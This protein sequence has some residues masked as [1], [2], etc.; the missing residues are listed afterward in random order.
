MRNIYETFMGGDQ[1]LTHSSSRKFKLSNDPN[2][3]KWSKNTTSFGH[4]IM[5]EQGWTPGQFL[6]A[7]DAPHAEFHT[8]AN[9]SHIR[10]VLKDDNLGI[11][12][13]KGS[14]VNQ[15]ECVGLDV[16]QTLL[17]RLNSTDEEEYV[18]EQNRREDLK[19]AIYTEQKWGTIRFVHGGFLIG[20]KIQD[21][22]DGEKERLK[23]LKEAESDSESTSSD[24]DSDSDSDEDKLKKSKKTIEVE[25]AKLTLDIKSK[26]RKSEDD[27]EDK[28]AKK[29]RKAAEKEER[30]AQKAAE[31][32]DDSKLSKK[33]R[34]QKRKERKAGKE[35]KRT[36]KAA[37]KEAKA[38]AKKDGKK[39]KK[40][41][42]A[43]PT[44]P[45]SSISTPRPILQSGRLAVRARN[46]E[47]KRMASMASSSINEVCD[48]LT[49]I[50]H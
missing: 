34:K 38:A 28:A 19:R 49:W 14:G 48:N 26:K 1:W 30:K 13:K 15:G 17:G 29:A 12:A 2:N 7:Q 8:E 47:A 32:E 11:G 27:G 36:L 23:N 16:F 22:I 9:A 4:K 41:S 18:K 43:V 50:V 46:I 5:T 31:K 24:S 3:T 33:E 44:P 25:T 45:I 37:K 20:D 21:L 6:G 39:D 42:S 40:R 10:V 35:K